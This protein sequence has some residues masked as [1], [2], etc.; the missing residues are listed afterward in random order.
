[1]CQMDVK[2]N[3]IKNLRMACSDFK[4]QVQLIPGITAYSQDNP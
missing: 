1:M 4:F 3:F 2:S